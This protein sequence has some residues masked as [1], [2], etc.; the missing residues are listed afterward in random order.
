[1]ADTVF[2]QSH[3]PSFFLESFCNEPA[4]T[5]QNEN[6]ATGSKTWL[7]LVTITEAA[8]APM[9]GSDK[10]PATEAPTCDAPRDTT[11]KS[12]AIRLDEAP[13]AEPAVTNITATS[14]EAPPC[15]P[16]VTEN[17]LVKG[18]LGEALIHLD[19]VAELT[20]GSPAV[21]KS[22]VIGDAPSA[23]PP[24]TTLDETPET[25][26]GGAPHNVGVVATK[27]KA[28]KSKKR[29]A[30]AETI[31]SK[32]RARFGS[33][34]KPIDADRHLR[35][36]VSATNRRVVDG[37]LKFDLHVKNATL[38]DVAGVTKTDVKRQLKDLRMRTFN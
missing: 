6:T 34:A 32:K 24:V 25:G 5:T 31:Q 33:A 13:P 19:V 29:A 38:D 35:K 17:A 4:M 28:V 30:E 11:N 22:S 8:K 1:M 36:V 3:M 37:L 23:T 26:V 18:P 14:G 21:A 16:V 7:S 27:V 10:D 2:P 20:N 9:D 15:G 12:R